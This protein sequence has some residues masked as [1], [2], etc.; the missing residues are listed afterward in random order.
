ME[1]NSIMP[2]AKFAFSC[3]RS[4]RLL[5]SGALLVTLLSICQAAFAQGASPAP[6]VDTGDTAWM[7]VSTAFVMLM[8]IGL[9]LFYGGMVRAKNTLN[10]LM[11]SFVALGIVTLVWVLWGYSLAF[12]PGGK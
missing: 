1:E 2:R 10:M 3:V 7:L 6:K 5:L 8:T 12:C 4:S 9:A 11:Q